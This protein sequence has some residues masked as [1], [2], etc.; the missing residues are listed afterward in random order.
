MLS[1]KFSLRICFRFWTVYDFLWFESIFSQHKF[2]YLITYISS[3][4]NNFF[5]KKTI[6][7]TGYYFVWEE[8][9]KL[10][11]LYILSPVGRNVLWQ[12]IIF[13][14]RKLF[15]SSGNH[16]ICQELAS[17]HRKLCFGAGNNFFWQ[18]MI[19]FDM[20]KFLWLQIIYFEKFRNYILITSLEFF[21]YYIK[22]EK[23]D[24][25]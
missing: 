17:F 2:I 10:S 7:L 24:F 11:G 23:R 6:P 21:S 1:E 20:K 13:S 3:T 12:E 4:I 19:S 8:S 16:F 15:P 25:R 5:W 18:E 22:Q 9:I 14:D